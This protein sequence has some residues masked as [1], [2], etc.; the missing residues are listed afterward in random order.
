MN[1]YYY[2]S[3]PPR[4][5]KSK[6]EKKSSWS[7]LDSQEKCI[8][9]GPWTKEEDMLVTKLVEKNGPQK[10]TYIAKHLPG[11][12]GKQCRERWHNHL[13]PNIRKDQWTQEEEWLLF[14]YHKMKGNRWAEIA[15][16]LKGR[17][18][19]SI[20]NHWNS[21]M[22]K[23]IPEFNNRYQVMIE[24]YDHNAEEHVCMVQE[25]EENLRRKRGRRAACDQN[26]QPRVPCITAHNQILS[27]AIEVYQSFLDQNKENLKSTPELSKYRKLLE[28]TPVSSTYDDLSFIEDSNITPCFT[29]AA[30]T[31]HT[32]PFVT[33]KLFPRLE[34]SKKPWNLLDKTP[35]NFKS[36]ELCFES[37]SCMLNLDHTPN[38]TLNF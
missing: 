20:K 34:S 28:I 9:T 2:P 15:K 16:I 21:S 25:P 27:E 13:N 12:I 17:T 4:S 19:N 31:N 32:S 5:R 14:L 18:D 36:P 23:K 3:T 33:P 26:D 8:K 35:E 22:K 30:K 6:F 11:R 1:S 29:P 10:W 7:P 38:R 24:Q 37:P